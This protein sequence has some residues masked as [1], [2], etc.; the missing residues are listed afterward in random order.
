MTKKNLGRK[1]KFPSKIAIKAMSKN[2]RRV[3]ETQRMIQRTRITVGRH[4]MIQNR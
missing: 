3:S 2:P 4:R 1:R